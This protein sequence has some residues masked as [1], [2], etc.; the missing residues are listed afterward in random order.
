M[1]WKAVVEEPITAV[2]E[3]EYDAV[4]V[5]ARLVEGPHGEMVRI[6]FMLA[7]DDDYDGRQVSGIASKRL[8]ENTKLGRWVSAILGRTPEVGEELSAQALLHKECRVVVKHKTNT[9]RKVFANVVQV[10][11][12]TEGQG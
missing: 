2:P 5:D 8:S 3:G 1:S 4:P 7:G 11:P 6:D 10:L 12:V 9:D